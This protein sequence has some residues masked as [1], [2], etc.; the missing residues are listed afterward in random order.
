MELH[1]D[2][3]DLG[4]GSLGHVLKSLQLPDLHSSRR[5]QD[6]SSLPHESSRIYL[7][8][9]SDDFGFTDPLLLRSRG[10]RGGNILGEDDILDEDT[11]DGNTPLV[12]GITNNFR[13]FE[14]DGFAL[15][16]DTLDG[17][18]T[19]DVT[20]GGLGTFYESLTKVGDTKGCPIGVSNLEVNDR[21]AVREV[22]QSGTRVG[23]DRFVYP[24]YDIDIV[25]GDDLLTSDLDNLDLDVYGAKGLC[26]DV[27]PDQS[28]VHGFVELSEPLNESDRSLLDVSERV[29]EG[30]AGHG[31][32]E[33]DAVTQ[34]MHR[35]A[36]ET[37]RD[38]SR[39]EILS[40]GRLHL[41]PLQGLD[42]ND[43]L[44]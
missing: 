10:K 13:D 30:A 35:R 31:A 11:F 3:D 39:T 2:E 20:E 8:A 38:I 34:A 41:A 24:H 12:C 42:V 36:V 16:N 18:C 25:P 22:F 37:V 27:D 15:G 44:G 33:T 21:V 23:A 6:I 19:D 7:R 1:R 17:T 26:A 28:R 14:S 40:I 29:G 4:A 43:V 5:S 32:E 9:G